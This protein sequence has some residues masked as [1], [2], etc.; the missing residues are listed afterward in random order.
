MPLPT[1]TPG[2]VHRGQS[3]RV[4]VAFRLSIEDRAHLQATAAAHGVSVQ[5]Y[6]ERVAL[7]RWD[8]QD[9]PSGPIK[10]HQGELPMTG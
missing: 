1:S 2:H 9:L 8:A 5:T 3:R 7:G 6:L 10:R 4:N